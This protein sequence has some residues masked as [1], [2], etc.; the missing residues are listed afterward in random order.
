MKCLVTG[1]AGFIGSHLIEYLLRHTDWKIVCLDRLDAAG[2]LNRLY[3]MPS[4]G[5]HRHRVA[6]R[7]HDL[8]A[9][10]SHNVAAELLGAFGMDPFDRV[11]HLA[12]GSHVDRSV[13]EPTLFVL[14][15]VLGTEHLL[16][17][18]LKPGVFRRDTGRALH[19]ST[20]EVFG[21]APDGT[22]FLPW[23]RFNPTNVYAATKAGAEALAI[24]CAYTWH[25]PLMVSHCTNVTGPRQAPE[26]F[27][28]IAMD[29][30]ASGGSV[31]IHAVNG[32]VCS[33]Y[34]VDVENVCSA[35]LFMLERGTLLDG[36][37]QAG[38]YNISGDIELSNV[39]LCTRIAGLMGRQLK[40][41]LV[42]NPPGRL[43]PDLRYS[44]DD[45]DLRDLGWSPAVTFNAGL[46]RTVEAFMS[47][48]PQFAKKKAAAE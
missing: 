21:S 20:D 43:R 3:D 38:R 6:F 16:E 14:D 18:L 24:A 42:E 40:Y 33:R 2:S 25:L 19:M 47:D 5:T 39:E 28:P 41:H 8:R 13:V 31:P 23:S 48:H 44:I 36:S 17:F 37:E 26:K 45:S 29:Q 46:A 15:N 7:H 30:I 11:F 1:G 35:L 32:I 27:L 22:K 4:W 12:A 34:Y 9:S 10:V